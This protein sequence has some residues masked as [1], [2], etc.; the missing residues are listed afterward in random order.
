M[1]VN[2]H[3]GAAVIDA[4]AMIAAAVANFIFVVEVY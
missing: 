1:A 2:A 4:V 3:V